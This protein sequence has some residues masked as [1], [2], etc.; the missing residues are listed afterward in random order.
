MANFSVVLDVL[1]IMLGRALSRR[2]EG[3]ARHE[4]SPYLAAPL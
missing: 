2:L 4:H 1:I 3:F